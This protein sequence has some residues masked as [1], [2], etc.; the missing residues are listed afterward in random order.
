MEPTVQ[1][2]DEM[3]ADLGSAV[4]RGDVIVLRLP[5]GFSAQIPTGGDYV[6]RVIGLPGDQ[7]ACCESRGRVAVNYKALNE[8]YLY[9][10]DSPSTAPFSVTLGSGQLWVLG[11]HRSDA[12]DSRVWGP[13]PQSD[14]VGRVEEISGGA[15]PQVQ[16]PQTFV[17]EG[18]APPDGRTPTVLIPLGLGTLAALTLLVLTVFGIVRT[19]IRRRRRR[20]RPGQPPGPRSATATEPPWGT[21]S[22]IN[23]NSLS[24]ALPSKC[25]D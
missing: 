24:A 4:R 16:T 5:P 2:G 19:V 25:D 7:V 17:A 1:P 6:V 15:S 22:D 9:P 14:V 23:A 21:L 18:L 10:G 8:T 13:V 12:V 3:L 11:D 20:G